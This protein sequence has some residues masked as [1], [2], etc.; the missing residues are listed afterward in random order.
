MGGTYKSNLLLRGGGEWGGSN[1]LWWWNIRYTHRRGNGH[2][3]E[4]CHYHYSSRMTSIQSKKDMDSAGSFR[5]AQS[6]HPH[7]TRCYI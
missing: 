7:H 1:I 2:Q 4:T 3:D 5:Y 6:S